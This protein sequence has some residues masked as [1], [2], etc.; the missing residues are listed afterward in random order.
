M[1]R[2]ATYVKPEG[3]VSLRMIAFDIAHEIKVCLHD[4]YLTEFKYSFIQSALSSTHARKPFW[5]SSEPINI[6]MYAEALVAI[7]RFLPQEDALPLFE[8]CVEPERSEAVKTCVVRA[9]ITLA[10]EAG[11]IKWQK[12]LGKLEDIVRPRLRSI[13]QSS[14]LRHPEVDQYGTTK[15]AAARPKALRT[16]PHSLSD[17]EI[18]I[19]GI[20]S[21]WR[22]DAMFHFHN[23]TEEEVETWIIASHQ[24]WAEMTDNSIKMSGAGTYRV[25]IE[26]MSAADGLHPDT[27]SFMKVSL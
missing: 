5:E 7:Y 17:R 25:M 6:A 4:S 10:E 8:V 13:F 3:E 9:C 23:M 1:C 2:A 11:R 21:L 14:G 12:P 27:L 24:V 20:L 18:L 15:R 22:T 19:L 16:T 26:N